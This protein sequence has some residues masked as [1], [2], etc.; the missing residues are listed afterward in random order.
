MYRRRGLFFVHHIGYLP[1]YLFLIRSNILILV[2]FISLFCYLL[3]SDYYDITHHHI[4]NRLTH[5]ASYTLFYCLLRQ[6]APHIL[7]HM[8][9]ITHRWAQ[10]HTQTHLNQYTRRKSRRRARG[11]WTNVQ[12]H[13]QFR[14]RNGEKWKPHA[15]DLAEEERPFFY[16]GRGIILLSCTQEGVGIYGY[17]WWGRVCI[18]MYTAYIYTH[19]HMHVRRFVLCDFRT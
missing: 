18:H 3:A 16:W 17:A 7:L 8:R 10:V 12:A 6:S 9:E 1:I 11:T 14:M 2:W 19:R 13:E 4:F 5:P 15:R